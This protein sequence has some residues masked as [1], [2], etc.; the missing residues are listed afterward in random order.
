M[1]QCRVFDSWGLLAMAEQLSMHCA[2]VVLLRE[3][4]HIRGVI[5]CGRGVHLLSTKKG[6]PLPSSRMSRA[7]ARGP[8]VPM[9]S[10]SCRVHHVQGV[11]APAVQF[12]STKLQAS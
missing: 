1:T 7:S 6:S 8:A 3:P 4:G 2:L 9:G 11:W 5:G 10:F 12:A